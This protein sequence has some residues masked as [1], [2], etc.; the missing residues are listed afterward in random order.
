MAKQPALERSPEM[1][2]RAAPK[3]AERDALRRLAAKQAEIASLPIQQEHIASW[4]RLNSNKTGRPMVWIDEIPWH[5]MDIAGELRLQTEHPLCRQ[6]EEALRKTIYQWEHMPADMVVEP[7]FLV[8]LTIHDSGF[9]MEEEAETTGH[10]PAKPRVETDPVVSRRYLPQIQTEADIEKIRTP[11]VTVDRKTSELHR[12]I[13]SDLFG[14]ILKV[15]LVGIRHHWFA[16]WDL[17][18]SWWG[19]EQA[20]TDIA[21]KP[22][23]VHQAMRRLMD[24]YLARMKQWQ[25]LN[26]LS[27]GAGNHRVGSGGPGLTDELPRPGFD[28]SHVRPVDQWGCATAQVFSAVS[29]RMH[30]EFALRYELEWLSRFGLNYYGCCEPLHGKIGILEKIPGLRKISMSPWADIDIMVEN[31]QG[32]YVLSYKPNPAILAVSD[33]NPARV[34]SELAEALRRCKGCNVEIIM[35]D[36][37]TV[38]SRPERLFEWTRIAAEVAG[39]SEFA[40]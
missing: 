23:L 29:A 28:P 7:R 20:L 16:P 33:W 12:E 13:I 34:R 1:P 9:G 30:G 36:I 27:F 35:K 4:K 14:D 40:G 22:A 2:Y 38:N 39:S 8:D 19:V 25:E 31:T 3:R 10:L 11:V 26:L 5:E 21:L 6:A 18:V 37:S 32:R 24:A 17:L 15:E